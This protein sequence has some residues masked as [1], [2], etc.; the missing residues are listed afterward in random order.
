LANIQA[1]GVG[2]NLTAARQVVF[3]D[4]D[5]VPANHWQAEDRAYRIGQTGTVNVTYMVG[6]HSVDEFVQRVLET[7]TRLVE[8]VIEGKLSAD[9]GAGNI[10][11]ELERLFTRLSPQLADR[12]SRDLSQ[13][14]LVAMLKQAADLY[15]SDFAYSDLD[16]ATAS[17]PAL[18]EDALRALAAVLSGPPE[19]KYRIASRSKPGVYNELTVAADGDVTC[20]CPG[21]SYRGMCSHARELKQA[22]ASGR[23]PAAQF[24]PVEASY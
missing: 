16:R 8:A 10:L 7:K 13:E 19:K 11:D 23:T 3:N 9:P 12:T 4:L 6:A 18:T 24:T 17:A 14:E 5:W 2:L 22:L 20:D 15:R 1:G 21:F